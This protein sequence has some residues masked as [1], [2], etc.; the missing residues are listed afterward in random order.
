[1]WYHHWNTDPYYKTIFGTAWN[2]TG[3]HH[4]G[5]KRVGTTYTLFQDGIETTSDT[6][7]SD[8]DL[9]YLVMGNISGRQFLGD[10]SDVRVYKRAL[11]ADEIK[12]LYE[13]R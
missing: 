3:W 1:M 5:I 7:E 13:V 12:R 2:T 9:D 8:F 11:S 10:M 4:L 6:W